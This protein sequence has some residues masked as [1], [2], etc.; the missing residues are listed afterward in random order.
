MARDTVQGLCSFS[1]HKAVNLRHKTRKCH[2]GI[3]AFH[4]KERKHHQGEKY[5]KMLTLEQRRGRHIFGKYKYI[6]VSNLEFLRRLADNQE[7]RFRPPDG[8]NGLPH[9]AETMSSV[10]VN[11]RECYDGFFLRQN[12]VPTHRPNT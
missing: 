9:R 5:Q 2:L 7:F 8:T 6:I 12:Q 4:H 3:A 1:L 11:K 10:F